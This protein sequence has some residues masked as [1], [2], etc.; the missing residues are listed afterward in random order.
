MRTPYFLGR[1]L[2]ML[3][4]ENKTRGHRPRD[5]DFIMQPLTYGKDI[6]K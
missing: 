5:S 6:N 4:S 2:H 3:D 1:R